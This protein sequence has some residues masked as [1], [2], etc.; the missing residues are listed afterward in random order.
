[1]LP[2][3]GSQRV[4]HDWVTELNWEDT[5]IAEVK[6]YQHPNTIWTLCSWINLYQFP[7]KVITHCFQDGL[8]QVSSRLTLCS[9]EDV[10]TSWKNQTRGALASFGGPHFWRAE[11]PWTAAQ[12]TGAGH[13]NWLEH[14]ERKSGQPRCVSLALATSCILFLEFQVF[15]SD[16]NY[17]FRFSSTHD[18]S[19]KQISCLR[20][21]PSSQCY[22]PVAFL[23]V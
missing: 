17:Y 1:M 14:H 4:G 11:C 18:W 5:L 13:V 3:M 20:P 10:S 7:E 12:V 16:Y 23:Q 9:W 21:A 19:N 2:S 6:N 8:I 15:Y 22:C